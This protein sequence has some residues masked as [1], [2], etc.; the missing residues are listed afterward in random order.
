MVG[1]YWYK[2]PD[3]LRIKLEPDEVKRDWFDHDTVIV[4]TING[5][6]FRALVPTHTL[7]EKKDSVPVY[8]AGMAGDNVILHFPVSNEGRPSWVIPHSEL[9][10]IT[11]GGRTVD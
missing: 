2:E 7:S 11:V 6:E 8:V 5:E 3:C 4:K 10:K 1:R 9:C